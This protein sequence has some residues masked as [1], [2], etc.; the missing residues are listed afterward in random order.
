MQ[1]DPSLAFNVDGMSFRMRWL[2]SESGLLLHELCARA[3]AEVSKSASADSSTMSEL[4]AALPS[5]LNAENARQLV[6]ILAPVISCEMTQGQGDYMEL[7]Q[8]ASD[9][10]LWRHKFPDIRTLGSMYKVL[11]QAGRLQLA[12]LV[13]SLR[14]IPALAQAVQALDLAGL[15][16]PT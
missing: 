4:L 15:G 5:V 8:G 14:S 7:G 12:P 6:N 3:L 1:H 10:W 16:G 11:V 13:S 9:S 2:P